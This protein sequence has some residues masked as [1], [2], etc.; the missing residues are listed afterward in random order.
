MIFATFD[1]TV[2][3][4]CKTNHLANGVLDSLLHIW[5]LIIP[6]ALGGAESVCIEAEFLGCNVLDCLKVLSYE[7]S[8]Q[9]L[10]R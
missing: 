6:V 1:E 2:N 7:P 9:M 10:A 3:L 5:I 4:K 8:P